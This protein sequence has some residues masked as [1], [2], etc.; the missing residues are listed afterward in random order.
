[1]RVHW[2]AERCY[3]EGRAFCVFGAGMGLMFFTV[4]YVLKNI[5]RVCKITN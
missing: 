1:M 3:D 5:E 4:G 2:I